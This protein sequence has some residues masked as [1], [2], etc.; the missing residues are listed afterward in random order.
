MTI[1]IDL[2]DYSGGPPWL[3]AKR[4]VNIEAIGAKYRAE[5]VQRWP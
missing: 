2:N 5:R 3:S 4:K 1:D